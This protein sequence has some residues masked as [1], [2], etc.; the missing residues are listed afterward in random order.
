MGAWLAPAPAGAPPPPADDDATAAGALPLAAALPFVLMARL[1]GADS[2]A[3]PP[4][5]G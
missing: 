1:V 4:L 5:R 3:E 2:D